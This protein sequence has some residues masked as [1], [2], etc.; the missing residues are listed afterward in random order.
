MC[1]GATNMIFFH[2]VV[3]EETLNAFI[4]NSLNEFQSAI[5]L[6]VEY[7]EKSIQFLN[8]TIIIETGSLK[9]VLFAKPTDTC[10]VLESSFFHP[11]HCKK[12]SSYSQALQQ[13][14]IG[15]IQTIFLLTRDIW[16]VGLQKGN[17]VNNDKEG[18]IK[19]KVVSKRVTIRKGRQCKETIKIFITEYYLYRVFYNAKKIIKDSHILIIPDYANKLENL[20]RLSSPYCITFDK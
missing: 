7:S 3:Q 15:C 10:Q 19:S 14:W 17:I 16:N 6:K 4:I 5:K 13:I 20:E 8:A 11:Y 9:S 18:S 1:G 12:D 2:M